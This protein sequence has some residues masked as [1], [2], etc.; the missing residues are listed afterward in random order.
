[1]FNYFPPHTGSVQSFTAPKTGTYK[2]EVWGAQ[3]GSGGKGGY[4]QGLYKM[5]NEQKTFVCVGGV[6]QYSSQGIT[7]S[8][9]G[10]NGGGNSQV[11]INSW[12]G[13]GG[14]GATH[15]ALTNRGILKNYQLY[16]FEVLIV[17]GGGGNSD[18]GLLGG[19]GGGDTGTDA[20]SSTG[21]IGGKGGTQTAGG[22]GGVNGSFGQ[23]GDMPIS[24]TGENNWDS[25]GAGGGGWYGGGS[26]TVPTGGSGGG[27]S[28]HINANYIINA[29]M[30]TGVREG[31]GLAVI[32]Q[33]SLY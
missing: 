30:D 31:N 6:G 29:H 20:A 3:G 7:I 9:G 32:T 11:N 15:I 26:S 10:Y 24:P 4:S 22:V 27:G 13:G 23:G 14:G 16:Q 5:S 19:S 25:G 2:L 21:E 1:M 12:G 28:G 8:T 17:A 33:T 18:H